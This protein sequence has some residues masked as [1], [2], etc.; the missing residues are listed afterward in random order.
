M[1]W[2]IIQ[3]ITNKKIWLYC[4]IQVD[5][6]KNLIKNKIQNPLGLMQLL[7]LQNLLKIFY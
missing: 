3:I 5:F 2:P 7:S 1:S 6:E 4:Q